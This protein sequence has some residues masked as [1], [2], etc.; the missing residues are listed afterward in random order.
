MK[1]FRCVVAHVAATNLSS[2]FRSKLKQVKKLLVFFLSTMYA[3]LA[4]GLTQYQH[5]CKGAAEKQYSWTNTESPDKN[6]PCPICTSK[7]KK[8][9]EKKKG[10]CQHQ[11]KLVKLNDS[12][13]KQSHFDFSVKFWG[14]TIPNQLLGTVFDFS[15]VSS[16]NN[17]SLTY[18]SSKNPLWSNPLYILLCTYR[19]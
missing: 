8:L 4:L 7:D 10:C 17:K 2:Q 6:K 14:S 15:I 13:K 12:I 18:L 9:Q 3:V 11:S 16:N 1:L 19:I 5:I